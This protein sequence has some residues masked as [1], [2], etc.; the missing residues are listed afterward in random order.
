MLDPMT[1]YTEAVAQ[2]A[3]SDIEKIINA[4]SGTNN[5]TKFELI[6]R[7]TLKQIYDTA[8]NKDLVNNSLRQAGN[9]L[10][11]LMIIGAFAVDAC[12]IA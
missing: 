10:A 7:S 3:D 4:S 12:N 2:C 11:Q 9:Q 1:V 6:S 8:Q 5:L